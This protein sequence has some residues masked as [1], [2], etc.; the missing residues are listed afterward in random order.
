MVSK[1]AGHPKVFLNDLDWI[2]LTCEYSPPSLPAQLLPE[3][4][5]CDAAGCRSTASLFHAGK[6]TQFP[7]EPAQGS[8]GSAGQEGSMLLLPPQC[9]DPAASSR[10]VEKMGLPFPGQPTI[11]RGQP[12]HYPALRSPEAPTAAVAFPEPY[13]KQGSPFS[14]ARTAPGTAVRRQALSLRGNT[15]A[16][17]LWKCQNPGPSLSSH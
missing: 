14:F 6:Y 10:A 11:G 7:Q 15:T 9:T 17:Q 1:G 5:S 13:L 8:A 4:T 3:D 16:G 2:L 12:H